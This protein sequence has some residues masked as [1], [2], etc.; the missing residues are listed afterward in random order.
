[1]ANMTWTAEQ[2][3]VIDARNRNLLVSAAAGSG[4]TAVLV[5]RIIQIVTD[6]ENPVD[7]DR[8]LVMTFTNAAAAEMRERVGDALEKRLEENPGDRNLERQSTLIH[9]AKITTID[10]FCLGLIREHFNDLDIDPGFRVGDEGELMLLQADV[11]KDMLED[12]YGKND[13]RFFRFVDTYASGKED[14]GLEDLIRQVYRFSQSNP[15]PGEWIANC[16]AELLSERAGD[17][18]SFEKSAWMQFLIQDVRQ[19]AGEFCEQLSEAAEIAA[20]EDGPQSYIP[21]LAEDLRMMENLRDADTYRKIYG[22]L[23]GPMFGRLS[24]ARGKQVDPEKKEAAAGIRNR[25]KDAMK[26]MKELYAPESPEHMASDMVSLSD[27][28]LMLLELCEAF[29]D[30]YQRSKEEKNLVDFNDLE[31]FAL[32]IL[33]GRSEDHSPGPAADELAA[34]YE[35]ILVDEYQDSNEVQETL[36]R[37]VSRERFG[38][39]NV[40][41]VGDVKQSIYKFRLAKPEL[42]LE[43]YEAYGKEDGPYQKIE[44]HKNFRSRTEVLESINDIF[45]RIMTKALGNI[46]YTEDTALYAGA[47]YPET[48]KAGQAKTEV[49]LL[50]TGEE[51]FA[52]M[53]EEKA[54]YTAK[55]AEARLIAAK[56][57]ELTDPE[58]GMQIWNGKSGQYEPLKKKDIVILL[59]SLSGWSEEF[60]SVLG[61]EGIPAFA[62]SRTGY[63]SAVEVETV[64]NFLSVID[65]PM[66]DIPLVGVLKS[67]VVGLT[68]REL[69]MIMADFKRRADRGQDPGFYGAVCG[70]L[71]ARADS[72]TENGAGTESEGEKAEDRILKKLREFRDLLAALRRE[73]VYL[74]VHR[75]IYRIFELTGY[76]D[77]VSAMPA[78]K[79]RQANLNMLVEKAAAY[80]KTSY[81][82]LFDFIRYIEKLKKYDT[83]FGG[84]ARAGE[85]DDTV[86]IMS[87]HKSKGLEF[88]VVI[89]AGAGK[90][91]NR[92]DTRGKILIDEKLGIAADY[93]DPELRV[94]APT[95]KK[96][97]LSRR[98]SL[99]SMG[100]ELRIL[101]VAMTRAKEKLI[102]TAGDKYLENRMEKWGSVPEPNAGGRGL[103]FTFLSAAGSY[104]DWILMAAQGA[105]S[106]VSVTRVPVCDLIAAEVKGQEDKAELGLKLKLLR[107]TGGKQEELCPMLLYRYPHEADVT[108]H[109]KM[110][111]S[112]LKEQ[113]QFTD[114]GESDFLSTIPAFMRTGEDP[115]MQA[116]GSRGPGGAARGTAYHRVLE[117][118]NFKK[119]RNRA[120][121]EAELKQLKEE[122]QMPAEAVRM[123]DRRRL[124]VF[125]ES[126]LAERMR[127]ADENGK[128]HKESQFVMGIPA[129]LMD[130][131]DSDESVLIQGII[132]AWFEEEGELVLVDYKTDRIGE[133]EEQVLLDRYRLQLIYYAQALSQ[134]T[135]KKVKESVIYSLTLQKQILVF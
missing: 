85:D 68:D 64:L 49:F 92:Q 106:S 65:N 45:Y 2:K 46:R 41:M 32:R 1:M 24:A 40:F 54:D 52:A 82:S 131:A 111:V 120:D 26:K 47:P 5:E 9:H 53:D 129:R 126:P 76:Y 121:L 57:R 42:F 3:Q 101:Y 10:S 132:D 43:K 127:K 6:P 31:H 7:I 36:I 11:M 37:A 86:R 96:N 18:K 27:P 124:T 21:A 13:G 114:D 58:T 51:L 28:I 73:A 83:D 84:A 38:K 113:G 4:K 20:K 29:S 87:I 75:L 17:P 117:L 107:E 122:E 135:G 90:A 30:R 125:F 130:E 78:G 123:V 115:Q 22:I 62:E 44:L 25:V 63:F 98:I 48:P 39:P 134:I 72:G 50:N 74:P 79:T 33:T 104:L 108:L 70:Y 61:A 116:S 128:L 109:A 15:W 100:E 60:V 56:I 71:E 69:A 102:I 89:L 110:S 80:E 77:Y 118:L 81:Q 23:S 34:F 19:Q 94:K 16:R 103:P 55:E 12:Y 97:V 119:V 67:P 88:P 14:G 133:G 66:Q 99:E 105:E 93:M 8:L 59:R 91:F 112:E 95:L 35:E